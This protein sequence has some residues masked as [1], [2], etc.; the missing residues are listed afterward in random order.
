MARRDLSTDTTVRPSAEPSLGWEGLMSGAADVGLKIV[1]ISQEAKIAENM[2]KAQLDLASLDNEYRIKAEAD[3][4]NKEFTA[5]YNSR[6]QMI[7][8]GYGSQIDPMFRMQWKDNVQRVTSTSDA[9]LETW[10]YRQ[11]A[12]NAKNSIASTMENNYLQA[13]QDGMAYGQSDSAT[14]DNLMNFAVSQKTLTEFAAKNL[15]PESAKQILKD[16]QKDYFKSF[17]AGASHTNPQ[18][19]A[20]LLKDKTVGK[21][22]SSDEMDDFD[23]VIKRNIRAKTIDELLAKTNYG[24]SAMDV[25]YGDGDYF[26]KRNT[27]DKME[28][29][30]KLDNKTAAQARRVLSSEKA[31]NNLTSSEH[32]SDIINQM[33][34][35]N[36]IQDTN[37]EDYLTGVRNLRDEILA[38]QSEGKLSAQ[39]A[40]KLDKQL[41]SLSAQ[42]VAQSTQR[43]GINFYDAKEKFNAL[44]PQYR[45][46][47]VRELFYRTDGKELSPAEL[48]QHANNIIDEFN[49][50]SRQK[51]EGKLKQF[52]AGGY[53]PPLQSPKPG[54]KQVPLE[55]PLAFDKEAFMKQ[56][57]ITPEKLAATAKAR[58]M[59]EAQV[60][61][62][63]WQKVN[64]K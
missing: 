10:R 53:P 23:K 20:E 45:G 64:K 25:V 9:Q 26:T 4:F 37:S 22:F 18:K 13:N 41:R 51:V 42:K 21:L 57:S 3:P 54:D 6:R 56:H 27:I 12:T 17:I 11:A 5:D 19:A 39:D 61:N 2:S 47:A 28:L 63:I 60:L 44:A 40:Q 14:L 48:N 52:D 32:M 43:V 62:L 15:G 36:A 7:L 24:E 50:R 33:Y 16:Y 38:R 1:E 49:K 29:E 31:L 46:E 59:S 8:D 55:P 35:L 34:D 30:G 58:N